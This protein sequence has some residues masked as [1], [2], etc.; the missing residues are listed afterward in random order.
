M[1]SAQIRE[2]IEV[3]IEDEVKR[4]SGITKQAMSLQDGD[5]NTMIADTG[6]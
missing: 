2:K 5:G 1:I 6:K 4:E 3:L